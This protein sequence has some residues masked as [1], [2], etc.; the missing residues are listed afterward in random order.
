LIGLGL[1]NTAVTKNVVRRHRPRLFTSYVFGQF[2]GGPGRDFAVD[3]IKEEFGC[4]ECFFSL[5]HTSGK[6]WKNFL[7][8]SKPKKGVGIRNNN[9]F[10]VQEGAVMTSG[11][12]FQRGI[13]RGLCV[14]H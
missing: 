12:Y 6:A 14:G 4:L 5:P 13:F 9:S 7:P 10:G 8:P 11:E 3:T 1:G 2:R